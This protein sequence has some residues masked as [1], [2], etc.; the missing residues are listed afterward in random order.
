MRKNSLYIGLLLL[1]TPFYAGCNGFLDEMPDNRTELNTEQSI[2]SILVSAYPQSTNTLI[3]E[4]YSDN[5]DEN[6]R[7]Y[8]YWQ[9]LEDDLYH[10]KD[11]YEENQD[12][13]QAVWDDCYAAIASANNALNAIENLGNPATLNPQKGEALVCRAYAH[14][15]L[16]TT[17]CQVYNPATAEKELGITY[18]ETLQTT[19]SPHYERG[20]LAN[21]YHKIAADLEKG[22]P[23]ISDD[24]YS[25]PKYHFNKKAAYAF[26]A[27]FYLY[28]MQP[29][30][31]NCK[32]VIEYAD[33][34]LG[35]NAG[36]FLRDWKSLGTLS[37]NEG[38]QPNAYINASEPANLLILSTASTLGGIVDSGYGLGM[39]YSH[40]AVTA[41]EDCYSNGLW[42]AYTTFRQQPFEPSRSPKISFRRISMKI[43]DGGYPYALIPV[44]T[45]D[46]TLLCRAEAYTYLKQY[47]KAA[48]D[49]T[50]WQKAFTSSTIT[51]TPEMIDL[52]YGESME[53]YDLSQ[54]IITPKKHLSPDFVLEA[55]RQTSFIHCILHLR[56]LTTLGE[57]LRWQDVKRY[58]ITV[59]RRY[60]E[61]ERLMDVTDTMD[62]NDLRRVVQIPAN[63]VSAGIQ[64]NPR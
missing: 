42:G 10:W 61:N 4:F 53:Y 36:E 52:F 2:I 40:N 8:S 17:F 39:R 62:K 29:D 7:S 16:A 50:S 64:A 48:A 59:E 26:A 5:I 14:F 41:M 6:S 32:K 47:D 44:F 25:V 11:T 56:R 24:A 20:T 51:I 63:V 12:S 9:K 58:G 38:V 1:S 45:T 28:Y 19:V 31:S 33:K 35:N 60:F 37:P 55:G 21:V 46:E 18:M 13:P 3:G 23:L 15:I 30:F 43:K 54:G 49:I 22:I 27:R 57:G 34:V